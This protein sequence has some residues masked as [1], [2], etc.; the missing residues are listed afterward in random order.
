MLNHMKEEKRDKG[1]VYIHTIY[2]Y[3]Y[4]YIH[5]IHIYTCTMYMHKDIGFFEVKISC[6]SLPLTV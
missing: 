4:I 1:K 6:C 5:S 2:T 3:R